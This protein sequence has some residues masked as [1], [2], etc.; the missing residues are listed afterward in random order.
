LELAMNNSGKALLLAA[1]IVCGPVLATTTDASLPTARPL[2]VAQIQAQTQK[3][4]PVVSSERTINLTEENRY[5][6]REIVLK[7]PNVL[8]QTGAKAVIGDPAP[9]GIT[10]QPFPD[11]VTG[12]VP[13]LRSQRFFVADGAV[14]VVDPKTNKVADI[15]KQA[16]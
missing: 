14:V 5:I 16:Q 2:H 9:A 7:D 15:V 11:E 6:I 13:A 4:E 12:K 1:S 3:D 8:K 10:T